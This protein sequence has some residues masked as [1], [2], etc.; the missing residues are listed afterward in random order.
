MRRNAGSLILV[1]VIGLM[2][3]WGQPPAGPGRSLE[4]ARAPLT[5]AWPLVFEPNMGQSAPS[6][7][8]L[9]HVP[10]GTLFFA[11]AEVVLTLPGAAPAQPAA[12][13]PARPRTAAP[14]PATVV[15]VQFVGAA[16]GKPVGA[17]RLA[18]R[19]N[20][21]I[22]NDPARWQTGL[23]TYGAITYAGL[24]PGVDLRYSGA[25]GRLKGTYLVAAGADAGQIR[26]RYTGGQA[27][28]V[29]ADGNLQI[30]A[31][32]GTLTE[33]APL[34]WQVIGGRQRAVAARYAVAA[35]GSVGFALGAYDTAQPLVIDP[36]L[37]Y[38][39]YLGGGAS[40]DGRGIV[41]DAAGNMYLTGATGSTTFPIANAYQ[42]QTA[43]QGDAFITKLNPAG[44]TLI[45][46]TY[47]GG[48]DSDM[49]TGIAL[50]ATGN[51]YLTGSTSS[52]N[53]PVLNAFQSQRRGTTDGFIT[54]LNAAGSALVFSTYL[55]GSI[56]PGGADND[57]PAGL[58]V[59]SAGSA[60]VTGFTNTSDF[61]LLNAYQGQNAGGLW[62][63]FVTKLTP[64]GSALAYSTYLGGTMDDRGIGIAVDG[65]DSAYIAGI[66]Y[67]AVFPLL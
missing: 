56:S 13:G 20:Y 26:W 23:P 40:D 61:P 5:T 25:D 57:L 2:L 42:P 9:A 10:H 63:V 14:V 45:Y 34:A 11:P 22:G 38:A 39:S 65:A 15:R 12:T 46:S 1:M 33:Q 30:A 66:T 62:D 16:G 7:E 58:A 37:V 59:D 52:T 64:A 67:T 55:G 6:V 27:V 28:T 8:F 4:P 21:L 44:N 31:G 43:G 17:D 29:D 18:G 47:L 51:V 53:F 41:A 36:T 32:G 60:F 3:G 24:Y 50:D 54:K 48:S 19:V 49:P 35:D